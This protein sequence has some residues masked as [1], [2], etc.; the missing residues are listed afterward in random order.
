MPKAGFEPAIWP[1]ILRTYKYHRSELEVSPC[2][3]GQKES[4]L[5]ILAGTW[6]LLGSS[7]N[8]KKKIGGLCLL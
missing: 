1:I 3:T 2:K 8:H 6:W 4:H 5:G 7:P